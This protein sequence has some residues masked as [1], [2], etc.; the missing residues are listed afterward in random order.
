M[1][2]DQGY[3]YYDLALAITEEL[4]VTDHVLIKGNV[5]WRPSLQNSR[6]TDTT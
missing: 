2:I 4:G 6:N 5:R 1:N 3:E